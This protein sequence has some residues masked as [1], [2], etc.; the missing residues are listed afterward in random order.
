[1]KASTEMMSPYRRLIA[2]K[3]AEVVFKICLKGPPLAAMNTQLRI[4][5]GTASPASKS[6][7]M[8]FLWSCQ[9]FKICIIQN[10]KLDFCHLKNESK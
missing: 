1:M 2:E 8:R 9:Y 6:Y 10:C 4:N 7:Q 5:W 3:N